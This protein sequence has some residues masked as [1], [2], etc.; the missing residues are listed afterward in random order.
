MNTHTKETRPGQKPLSE[1]KRSRILDSAAKL[2]ASRPFHKVL[3]SDVAAAAAVGK[4]TLYLYFES[5]DELYLSVLFRSFANL[6]ARVREK[7]AEDEG[8]PEQRL[9]CVI[10]ELVYRLHG[11]AVI[12]ELLRGAVV[13]YPNNGEWE[14]KRG[15]LHKL[16]EAILRRGVE[17][18][19][20]Q[21]AH[22]EF[23]ARYIPGMIRAAILFKP[24]ATNVD[25]VFEH[26]RNFILSSLRKR[27]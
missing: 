17:K 27:S 3:L 18:G 2:F 24:E 13:G 4:G 26:A 1:E 9:S 7:L 6:V 14:E 22:P 25:V 20:F 15:E 11:N 10:R 21:D 8:E 23:T 5:K 19:V 12:K 16:I